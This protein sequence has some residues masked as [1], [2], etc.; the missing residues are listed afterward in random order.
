M[1]YRILYLRISE[2]SADAPYNLFGANRLLREVVASYIQVFLSLFN[3]FVCI[4]IGFNQ[5][6]YGHLTS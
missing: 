1:H 2:F 6:L 3:I 4:H 5:N